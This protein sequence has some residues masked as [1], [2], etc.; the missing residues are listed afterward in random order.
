MHAQ[1]QLNLWRH[2]RRSFGPR[3][4]V[5]AVACSPVMNRFLFSALFLL[6]TTLHAQLANQPPTPTWLAGAPKY[7]TSFDHQGRLL[8]AILLVAA[9]REVSISVNGQL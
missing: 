5:I 1:G 4:I 8:M 6:S 2:D 3:K 9:D 7:E